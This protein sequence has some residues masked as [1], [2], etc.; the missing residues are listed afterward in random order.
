MD[1][2]WTRAETQLATLE[3]VRDNYF[4]E[5]AAQKDAKLRAAAAAVLNA[6]PSAPSCHRTSTTTS[7]AA[8]SSAD[9]DTSFPAA[10][11]A[12]RLALRGR[13]LEASS[14]AAH[15]AEA[16]AALVRAVKLDPEACGAG[17]WNALGHSLWTGG[18][19]AQARACF[20]EALELMPNAESLRQLSMLLRA[21]PPPPRSAT[22]SVAAAPSESHSAASLRFAKEAVA[23]GVGDPRSWYVLGNAHWKRADLAKS[24]AA[25]SRAVALA[26]VHNAKAAEATPGAA[27]GLQQLVLPDLH[28]NLAQLLQHRQRFSEAARHYA[29]SAAADPTLPA[30]EATEAMVAQLRWC[31]AM[32]ARRGGVKPKRL[33]AMAAAM[34][35][36]GSASGGTL[37]E[38]RAALQTA[39]TAALGGDAT[40]AQRAVG[41]GAEQLVTKEEARALRASGATARVA[42]KLVMLGRSSSQP[43]SLLMIDEAGECVVLALYRVN[44]AVCA[45]WGEAHTFT[46]TLGCAPPTPAD[47][48]ADAAQGDAPDASSG[49]WLGFADVNEDLGALLGGS[50]DGGGGNAGVAR[51]PLLIVENAAA[52]FAVNGAPVPKADLVPIGS[53]AAMQAS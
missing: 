31:A 3:H 46:V 50:S 51:F 34:Y 8:G 18:E 13:A 12:R 40:R 42:L 4:P 2:E 15:D 35:G 7:N 22:P 36:A 44:A 41:G 25:Y 10:W 47:A 38:A 48:D 16:E 23:L 52:R 20:E 17:A 32:V 6:L 53:I 49:E 19:M 14:G 43:F 1:G 26:A 5:D 30:A 29:L 9:D 28:F 11:R 27:G 24:L 21:L 33:A 37:A 45:R 39:A